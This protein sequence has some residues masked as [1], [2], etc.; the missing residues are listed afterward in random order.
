MH[1]PWR[2][3]SYDQG[4]WKKAISVSPIAMIGPKGEFK[5]SDL[6]AETKQRLS[7]WGGEKSRSKS[8]PGVVKERENK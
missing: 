3:Y 6:P 8:C 7:L 4:H 2:E 1:E 5:H